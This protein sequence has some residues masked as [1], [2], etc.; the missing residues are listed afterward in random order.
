[1]S[2]A[3]LSLILSKKRP[4]S[5]ARAAEIADRLHLARREKEYLELLVRLDGAKNESERQSLTERLAQYRKKSSPAHYG[6]L[7]Q[8]RLIS[9]WF[10]LAILEYVTELAGPHSKETIAHAFGISVHEAET[11][12]A[13][14]RRLDLIV[15]QDD[16]IQRTHNRLVFESEHGH[17]AL[18]TYYRDLLEK[19]EES[20]AGTTSDRVIG[21]EVFAFDPHDLDA[22]RD[23]TDRYLNDLVALAYRGKNR[24]QIFQ[25]FTGI[26]NLQ[27]KQEKK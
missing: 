14:L 11:T 1:L 20:I 7:D 2:P 8:F 9:D 15:D 21:T 18:R 23:L 22:V 4:L 5:V 17:A 26:F 16:R 13:R 19:V 27:K 12:L 6:K 24:T 25:A 10:G 3:G